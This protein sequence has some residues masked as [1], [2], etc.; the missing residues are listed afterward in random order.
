MEFFLKQDTAITGA[1]H[2][3]A[4][5]LLKMLKAILSMMRNLKAHLPRGVHINRASQSRSTHLDSP[6]E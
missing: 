2:L 4:T 5:L 3:E 6:C 1:L